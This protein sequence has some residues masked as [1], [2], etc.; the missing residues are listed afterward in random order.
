MKL[1]WNLHKDNNSFWEKYH[2]QNSYTWITELLIKLNI[3]VVKDLKDIKK[4]DKL[5][6]VDFKLNTASGVM[7][8]AVAL[9][10]MNRAFSN[11]FDPFLLILYLSTLAVLLALRVVIEKIRSSAV[12]TLIVACI[13]PLL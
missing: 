12:P 11:M 1:F 6:V 10:E 4:K 2:Y 9:P 8:I 3:E 13:T 7:S 5:I